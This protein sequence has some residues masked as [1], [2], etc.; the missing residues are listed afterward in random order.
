MNTPA[1]NEMAINRIT[2][3]RIDNM[4]KG[5]LFIVYS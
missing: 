3:L 4:W 2:M 1:D 5:K